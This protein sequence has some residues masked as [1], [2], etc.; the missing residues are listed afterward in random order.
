MLG[1]LR[2]YVLVSFNDPRVEQQVCVAKPASTNID[3]RLVCCGLLKVKE[4]E[5][6][7]TINFAK[8]R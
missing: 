4:V 7:A 6:F 2:E 1:A 3:W 8:D 5:M